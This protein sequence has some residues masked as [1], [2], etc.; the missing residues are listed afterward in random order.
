LTGCAYLLTSSDGKHNVVAKSVKSPDQIDANEI[1]ALTELGAYYGRVNVQSSR[2]SQSTQFI[3]MGYQA[4]VD[5]YHTFGWTKFVSASGAKTKDQNM[6]TDQCELFLR[7]AYHEIAVTAANYVN[8]I[9]YGNADPDFNN[10]RF[11]FTLHSPD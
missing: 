6:P 9:G 4:G 10:V 1:G 7:G 2:G 5:I 3:Y 11:P 8:F